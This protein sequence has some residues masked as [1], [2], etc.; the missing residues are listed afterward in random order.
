M[1]RPARYEDIERLGDVFKEFAEES[2]NEFGFEVDLSV[3]KTSTIAFVPT[4]FVLIEDEKI[5]GVMAG[6]VAPY[7]L[8]GSQIYY[9]SIWYVLKEHRAKGLELL[10]NLEEY[11]QKYGIK[12]IVVGHMGNLNADKMKRFYES[13]GFVYLETKYIKQVIP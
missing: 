2:L 6:A 7:P 3:I 5:V 9:E 4:S 8:D 10:K 13:Q 12:R 11:C 1:I